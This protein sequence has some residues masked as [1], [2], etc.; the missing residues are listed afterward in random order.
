MI[1]FSNIKVSLAVHWNTVP[2]AGLLFDAK[3]GSASFS[4]PSKIE[5][6][7]DE[8]IAYNGYYY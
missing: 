6:L 5:L 3:Q 4:I 8:N 7:E 2:V 1:S